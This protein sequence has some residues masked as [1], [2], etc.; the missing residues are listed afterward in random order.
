MEA[1]LPYPRLSSFSIEEEDLR[2]Y[3]SEAL[4]QNTPQRLF[5]PNRGPLLTDKIFDALQLW[6][7]W[8]NQG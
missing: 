8:P 4:S 2:S 7:P 6:R 3:D 1:P 5:S